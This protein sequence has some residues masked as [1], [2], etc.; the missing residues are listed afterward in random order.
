VRARGFTIIELVTVVVIVG[1][2]AVFVVP[3]LDPE[4]FD[5]YGFRQQVVSAAR[6]A[7]KTAMASGCDV[8]LAVDAGADTVTLNYRAG[9]DDATCGTASFSEPLQRPDGGGAFSIGAP[10]GVDITAGSTLF[11][12]G[13]GHP[14]PGT[15]TTIP[16]ATG[17]A[18]VIEAE[19]GYAHE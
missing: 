10:D 6:Y 5:R 2:L 12:D 3:R 7:Q 13:Y 8:Q 1:A 11:F 16:F 17:P 18:I 15:G 4:G 14:N 9:G 19:T